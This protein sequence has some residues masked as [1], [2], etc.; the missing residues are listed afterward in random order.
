MDA[1][2]GRP[3]NAQMYVTNL[4]WN[5]LSRKYSAQLEYIVHASC[6]I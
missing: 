6:V 3:H 1:Y 2:R 4:K 5:V